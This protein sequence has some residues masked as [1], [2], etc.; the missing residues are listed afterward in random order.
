MGRAGTLLW[1]AECGAESDELAIGWRA[2]LAGELDE[3]EREGQLLMFC[4]D[5]TEPEFG[6]FGWQLRN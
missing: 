2:Y 3:D 5:C 6:P 1:C 4:P